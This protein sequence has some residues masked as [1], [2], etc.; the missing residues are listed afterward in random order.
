MKIKVTVLDAEK[1]PYEGKNGKG[2]AHSITIS[3]AP[4]HDRLNSELKMTLTDECAGRI[5][6]MNL[7]GKSIEVV[8]KELSASYGGKLFARGYIPEAGKA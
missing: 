1:R 4:G 5:D 8:I 2:I 6:V 3:E 7:I